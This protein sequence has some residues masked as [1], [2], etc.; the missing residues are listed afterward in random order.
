M[1]DNYFKVVYSPEA[2][3]DLI[4]IYDYIHLELMAQMNAIKQTNRIKDKI[5]SLAFMPE[6][7]KLVEW[8]PWH[9]MGVHSVPVDNFTIFYLV[10]NKIKTVTIVRIFYSGRNIEGIISKEYNI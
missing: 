5:R 10:E 7:H 2:L 8:E 9:S 6:R 1:M 3:E 4:S